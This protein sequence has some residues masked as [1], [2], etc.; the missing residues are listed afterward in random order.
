MRRSFKAAT[1]PDKIRKAIPQANPL[2]Y[3]DVPRGS[4]YYDPERDCPQRNCIVEAINWYIQVLK[5]QESPLTEKQ[6]ALN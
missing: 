4:N 5:S 3:V 2:H 6:I 1:W